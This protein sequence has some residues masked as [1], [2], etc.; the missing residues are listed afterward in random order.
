MVDFSKLL[1]KSADD[2]TKPKPVPVG[3]YSGVIKKYEY[4]ES[5]N[6]NKTPY[7]RFTVGLQAPGD[8]VDASELENVDLTKKSFRK[9]FYLTEDAQYRVKEFAESCG[10][11][12]SGRSLGEIIPDVVNAQV[13]VGITQQSSADGSEIYNNVSTIVGA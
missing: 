7:V 13:L 1:S 8:D 6:E 12:T 11:A 9:D 10:I 3:T 5:K 2:I 4:L